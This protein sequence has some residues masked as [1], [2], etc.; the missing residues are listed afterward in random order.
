MEKNIQI[1]NQLL[2]IISI[3]ISAYIGYY[4]NRKIEQYKKETSTKLDLQKERKMF[5]TVTQK[6][7][8]FII[9]NLLFNG[10]IFENND[11]EV[12][13]KKLIKDTKDPEINLNNFINAYAA[14]F[15]SI[16]LNTS[17]EKVMVIRLYLQEQAYNNTHNIS[18]IKSNIDYKLMI[19]YSLLY[20][21]LY[22]DFSGNNIEDLYMLRYNLTDFKQH[23]KEFN[24]IKKEVLDELKK[25]YNWDFLKK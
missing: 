11:V 25:N 17:S 16:A 19:C 2:P 15:N 3:L 12:K 23:Q 5:L 4:Y 13:L 20:K 9:Q 8:L 14:F 22:L 1:L 7:L 24:S 21:Y 10:Y 6:N 18:D